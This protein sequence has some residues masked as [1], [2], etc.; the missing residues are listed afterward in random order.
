MKVISTNIGK[1]KTVT[2]NDKQVTTGIFKS[3]VHEP[4]LLEAT[5]VRHDHVVDR[6][7]HG[8]VNKA[9]YL[10][11]ANHYPFWKALYP[12]LNWN[13]GMFGENL[14]VD[15]CIEEE[16]FIGSVYEVGT[17]KVQVVQPRQP[18]FKLGIRFNDQGVL[19]QFI[20]ET[21]SGIYLKVLE[22][23]QVSMGDE[24]RLIQED[25]AAITVAQLFQAIFKKLKDEAV[26]E[27]IVQHDVIPVGIKEYITGLM[28]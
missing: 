21:R 9:C 14:T 3:P 6:K 8:G 26:L 11:G 7:Y 1:A 10:Y 19:K 17:A 4:I 22:S 16:T 18:C 13:W 25:P 23:G 24:F 28:G 5:D 20:N 27:K 15:L 2:W 12:D